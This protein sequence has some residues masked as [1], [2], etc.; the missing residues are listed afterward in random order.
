MSKVIKGGMVCTADRTWKADVLV[1][2]ETITQIGPDLSGDEYV[3]AEG[4]EHLPGDP[5]GRRR[6]CVRDPR[7]D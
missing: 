6:R 1:E 5:C 3:D 7:C 4:L 2:G